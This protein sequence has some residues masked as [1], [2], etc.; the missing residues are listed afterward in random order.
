MIAVGG[1]G[2]L[3]V[4]IQT[5]TGERGRE[6]ARREGGADAVFDVRQEGTG[7]SRIADGQ[8]NL[9][10][11]GFVQIPL[12][13]QAGN[14]HLR[15]GGGVHS[16][17]IEVLK[18]GLGVIIDGGDAGHLAQSVGLHLYAGIDVDRKIMVGGKQIDGGSGDEGQKQDGAENTDE[19]LFVFQSGRH[20]LFISQCDFNF[21][22]GFSRHL[23]LS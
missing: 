16:R 1:S 17:E 5:L 15:G 18:D 23:N 2:A 10:V 21:G 14:D 20:F 8:K 13:G 19:Q 4:K 7:V 9:I 12:V 22:F 6:V 11:I 3:V